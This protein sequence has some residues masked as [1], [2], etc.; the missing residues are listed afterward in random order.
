LLKFAALL[1]MHHLTAWWN[2]VWK[3]CILDVW[4]S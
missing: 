2:Y 1:N 4:P 3:S